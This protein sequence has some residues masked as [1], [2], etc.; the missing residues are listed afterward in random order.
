LIELTDRQREVWA[1][2]Q[3]DMN[4]SEIAR[5]LGL[6]E[7]TVRGHLKAAYAKAELSDSQPGFSV[8]GRTTLIK[9]GVTVLEWVKT[10][11]EKEEKATQGLTE[12]ID[13]VL[14]GLSNTV[15][16]MPKT[17]RPKISKDQKDYMNSFVFGDAHLNM[18]AFRDECIGNDWD[19]KIAIKRHREA[20]LQLIE[21][22]LPAGFARL[23]SLGDLL[24]NDSMRPQT[25]AGT[26]VDVDGRMGLALDET[27]LL[28][29][30]MIDL[31]LTIYQEIEVVLARGN[32][33]PTMELAI[34]KM[35]TIAYEKEPRVTVI[36]NEPKHIPLVWEKNFQLITHGD[37]LNPQK[38][39]DIATSVFRA[40]HGA[41]KFTHILSGHL[42]HK[43]QKSLSGCLTEVFEVLPTPDCW[44]TESGFV[45]SD[46]S[47]CVL[48]Y[49][50]NGGIIDR[51][52]Y[53]PRFYM[54][55]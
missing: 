21:N 47:A 18:R 1:L 15:P 41:A 28:L 26:D 36:K 17:K 38:K 14:K 55:D 35:I 3:Q 50:K 7:A 37:K 43:D 32:H 9:D 2:K 6:N 34:S 46:Q 33:P 5:K 42:H 23:I 40:Q 10:H 48:R 52:E 13:E 39:A 11:K 31:M 8:K 29:R 51:H 53:N 24:H 30:Y 4:N 45:T 16:R 22:A 27:V 49:H 19:L 44:H 20:I 25:F 12:I 54:E